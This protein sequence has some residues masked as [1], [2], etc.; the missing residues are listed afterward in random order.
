MMAAAPEVAKIK[1]ELHQARIVVIAA[2]ELLARAG[3][4]DTVPPAPNKA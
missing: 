4:L 2:Q 3:E 1:I